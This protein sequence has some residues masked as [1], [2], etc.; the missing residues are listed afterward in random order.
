MT[1]GEWCLVG[2]DSLCLST[3]DW[4]AWVQAAGSIA[5]IGIAIAIPLIIHATERKQLRKEKQLRA[6]SYALALLPGLERHLSDVRQ[7]RWR[8]TNIEDSDDFDAM[9]RL[10]AQESLGAHHT[11][12]HE[13]GQAGSLLQDA[14]A[15]IP[16]LRVLINDHEFY[17]RYG[18][19]YHEQDGTEHDIP[20][21][22]DARPLF[23]SALN[24]LEVA[25]AAIKGMFGSQDRAAKSLR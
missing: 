10:L 13:L 24:D 1:E 23:D 2:F 3:S 21:P 19:T 4:A 7:A 5:A 18:G 15:R 14:L 17:A 11:S 6:K 16:K 12:L 22:D 25:L 9:S 20:T 8:Y